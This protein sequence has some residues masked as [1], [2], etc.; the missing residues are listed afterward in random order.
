[1]NI[2]TFKVAE[3]QDVEK[4]II[5]L[6][7]YTVFLILRSKYAKLSF[8]CVANKGP[9]CD[10]TSGAA[11]TLNN[12]D[13]DTREVSYYCSRGCVNGFLMLLPYY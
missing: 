9:D 1:M 13:Q 10:D 11:L 2:H 3:I 4:T 5:L 12:V 7:L 6:R 8:S